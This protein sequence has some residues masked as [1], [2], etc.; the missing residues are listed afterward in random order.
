MQP[1]KCKSAA[2][3]K[4]RPTHPSTDQKVLF[5]LLRLIISPHYHCS[6][7]K[8]RKHQPLPHKM[9]LHQKWKKV[10]KRPPNNNNKEFRKKLQIKY[11]SACNTDT[12]I[13]VNETTKPGGM[14][15][16]KLSDVVFEDTGIH[17]LESSILCGVKDVQAGES[18]KKMGWTRT[19]APLLYANLPGTF[20][21][22][23]CIN[24]LN[25]KSWENVQKS[26]SM[27]AQV[28]N[29]QSLMKNGIILKKLLDQLLA[30]TAINLTSKNFQVLRREALFGQTSKI[31]RVGWTIGP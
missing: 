5:H 21:L 11:L 28:V 12:W 18:P 6:P 3:I 30:H 15:A 22:Y 10:E 23:I 9:H 27:G 31:L 26:G 1:S 20:E 29:Q 17:V 14:S 2:C 19:I 4:R 13:Y 8:Q 7:H 25:G 16:K 24:Q